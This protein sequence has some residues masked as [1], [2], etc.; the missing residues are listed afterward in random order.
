MSRDVPPPRRRPLLPPLL[1][2]TTMWHSLFF[3]LLL[4]RPPHRTNA[5]V[6][7]ISFAMPKKSAFPTCH[8]QDISPRRRRGG[9]GRDWPG[10][11]LMIPVHSI[12]LT[13]LLT[14]LRMMITHP[15]P[16]IMSFELP[17]Q[18]LGIRRLPLTATT[19]HTFVRS[20][21]IVS[22]FTG[23]IHPCI[24]T[25]IS[26]D[27]MWIIKSNYHPTFAQ[28]VPQKRSPHWWMKLAQVVFV[29]SISTLHWQHFPV[30]QQIGTSCCV[31]FWRIFW[32][33]PLVVA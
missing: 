22:N 13:I 20:C 28:Y 23:A 32:H 17:D 10:L 18:K 9:A 5:P 7:P 12:I 27:L 4:Q 2:Q 6:W 14:M 11:V 8:W 29:I 15:L 26:N 3:P 19:S 30:T 16:F 24:Q 25:T 1:S 31:T 33:V 21:S